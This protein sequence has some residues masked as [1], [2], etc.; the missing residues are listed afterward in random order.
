MTRTKVPWPKPFLGLRGTSWAN[1]PREV[2]AGITLAAMIIPLNIGFTQLA[3]LPPTAGLYAGNYST[4]VVRHL[5]QFAP[6]C[7]KPGCSHHRAPGGDTRSFCSGWRSAAIAVCPG[8]CLAVRAAVF[9]V[10]VFS[11]G[12][13]CQLSVPRG[14][15]WF[16]HRPGDRGVHQSGQKGPWGLPCGRRRIGSCSACRPDTGHIGH[17]GLLCGSH[18]PDSVRSTREL[19]FGRDRGGHFCHRAPDET[20]HA[21]DTRVPGGTDRHDSHRGRVRIG[22]KRR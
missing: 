5:H 11:A 16:H 3:G 7:Y 8:Y 20:V 9:C 19:V 17:H 6:A 14:V 1:A 2:A 13:S 22:W 12:V 15:G 4:R 18:R 10:L 21:Q